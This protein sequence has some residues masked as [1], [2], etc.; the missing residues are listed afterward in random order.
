MF[1]DRKFDW[2][3]VM[4]EF[5]KVSLGV[6][7]WKRVSQKMV[8]EKGRMEFNVWPEGVKSN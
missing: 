4:E 5:C 8:C 1:D 6:E 2:K 3:L 7:T